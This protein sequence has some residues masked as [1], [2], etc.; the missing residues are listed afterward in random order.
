GA[1]RRAAFRAFADGKVEPYAQENHMRA[2]GAALD[3]RV[4]LRY[5]NTVESTTKRAIHGRD[6]M[7]E[8]VKAVQ[9]DGKAVWDQAVQNLRTHALALGQGSL[10]E[11]EPVN[12]RALRAAVEAE[13]GF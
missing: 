12:L 9:R 8:F 5:D 11:L 3:D 7:H 10:L 13:A 4:T 2:L 1:L 6:L